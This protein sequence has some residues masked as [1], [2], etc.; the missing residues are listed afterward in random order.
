MKKK[1]QRAL[2]RWRTHVICI[3]TSYLSVFVCVIVCEGV[4][5]LE[6][7]WQNDRGAGK[8]GRQERNEKQTLGVLNL[9]TILP[10]SDKQ[11]TDSAYQQKI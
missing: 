5:L 2:Q 6:L 1:Q 8:R 3:A 11:R 7:I 4:Y 9:T 10:L